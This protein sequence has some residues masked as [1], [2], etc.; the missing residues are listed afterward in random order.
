M[1]FKQKSGSPFLRNFGIGKSPA[2]QQSPMK[3]TGEEKYRLN[4]KEGPPHNPVRYKPKDWERKNAINHNM[5]HQNNPDWDE[6]HENPGEESAL[7]MKSPLE[8]KLS[9]MDKLGSVV[10]AFN[11]YDGPF[12]TNSIY[13]EYKNSKKYKRE[14]MRRE[15]LGHKQV[16]KV[17][18]QG[19]PYH[20]TVDEN[21]NEIK[22]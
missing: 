6:N 1:A 16:K 15:K 9:F 17:S 21:G 4:R 14:D 3:D 5:E 20:V 19:Q 11:R 18:A 10:D 22:E 2:K 7:E 12:G 8:Q 13:D